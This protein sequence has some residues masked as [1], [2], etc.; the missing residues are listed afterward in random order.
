MKE[1]LIFIDIN[2]VLNF[3][4][5]FK[6]RAYKKR[7][8]SNNH[9]MSNMINRYNLF[10]VGLLCKLTKAKVVLSS[11]WRCGWN[12][13]GTPKEIEKGHNMFQTDKLFRKFGVNIFSITRNGKLKVSNKWEINEEALNDW[14]NIRTFFG[15][16]GKGLEETKERE[17]VL[18]WG[19]GTQI[20]EWLER[21]NYKGTYIVID[22]DFQDIVLYKDLG[23]RIITTSYYRKFGGF[24][25][26][27]FIKGFWLLLKNTK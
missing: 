18:K 3:R 21:N 24:R 11:S 15:K 23:N 4:Y 17:Y 8:K 16:T 14:C 5:F 25:F 20:I 26:K 27:H 2:G 6:S 9:D 10:W 1:R 7:A 12:E 22:D 19:R 13:D